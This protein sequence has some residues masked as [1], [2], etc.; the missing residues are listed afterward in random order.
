[1]WRKNALSKR[2][3][4]NAVRHQGYPVLIVGGGPAG[5]STAVEL[6]RLGTAAWVVERSRYNDV[7][8]GEHLQ[9][10][11]VLQ[12]RAAE[13]TLNM[14][15][16]V[17][18][19]S[20]GIEAYWGSGAPNYTDYLFHPGQHG[21][22]LSRPRFDA[23][24]A[25]TCERAGATVLRSATLMRAR[26]A[27][28]G[29]DA[30]IAVD[31]KTTS[32][33]VSVVVDASGRAARFARSQGAKVH[34]DDRMVAVVAIGHG[35]DNET[36]TRSLVETAEI[37]WWY[38]SR[39]G[40]TQSICMLVTDDDLLPK[41][42]HA[43]LTP[44]WLNQLERTDHTRRRTPRVDPSQRLIVRS[45]RSQHLDIASG[46]GWLAVG[47]AAMAL[48]PLTSQGIAKAL[49]HGRRAASSIVDYIAGDDSSMERLASQVC[50]DYAAYR[51]TRTRYY[52]LETRWPKSRFWKRRQEE[53]AMP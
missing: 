14:P 2:Q 39:I 6:A 42:A 9:P 47:D 45:A 50:S 16:D 33:A 3:S 35:A 53:L 34:A 28:A 8:V 23:D 13:R 21:L 25:R 1:L 5:L 31:G 10:S 44:W 22:N 19:V 17:H 15:L 43:C 24:L 49:E 26:K 11:G 40:P 29:W 48:D 4:R 18:V 52:R 30:D 7:R 38:S 20:A 46:S 51:V 36:T 32:C 37:G 12:L 27:S 41:G